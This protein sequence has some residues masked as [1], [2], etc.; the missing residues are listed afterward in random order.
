MVGVGTIVI[1]DFFVALTR[2]HSG[3]PLECEPIFAFDLT[4]G[5]LM[6][7]GGGVAGHVPSSHEQFNFFTTHVIR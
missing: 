2:D 1:W 3:A 5:R 4:G 7:G 6:E